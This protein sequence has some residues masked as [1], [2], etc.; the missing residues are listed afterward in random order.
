MN[1]NVKPIMG[2]AEVNELIKL[3]DQ[4]R[5]MRDGEYVYSTLEAAVLIHQVAKR[6]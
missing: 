6:R 3:V 2:E 4:I 5:L 1:D